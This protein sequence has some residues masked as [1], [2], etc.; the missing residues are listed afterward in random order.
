MIGLCKPTGGR[1]GYPVGAKLAAF[2]N[3]VGLDAK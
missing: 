1:W 3:D 2:R